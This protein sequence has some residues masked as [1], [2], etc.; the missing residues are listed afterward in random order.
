[1]PK[2]KECFSLPKFLCERPNSETPGAF[3]SFFI[4]QNSS[5]G[6]YPSSPAKPS[7]ELKMTQGDRVSTRLIIFFHD[8]TPEVNLAHPGNLG[9]GFAWGVLSSLTSNDFKFECNSVFQVTKGARRKGNLQKIEGFLPTGARDDSKK[10]AV[11]C[12]VTS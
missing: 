1:M 12:G 10:G 5:F 8:E 6:P 3:E 11:I 4:F 9:L 7:N 2:I